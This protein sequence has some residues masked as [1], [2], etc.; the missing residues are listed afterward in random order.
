MWSLR[1]E[2]RCKIRVHTRGL[3]SEASPCDKSLRLVSRCVPTF[4]VLNGRSHSANVIGNVGKIRGNFCAVGKNPSHETR[5]L[6]MNSK[7]LNPTLPGRVHRRLV[8][9]AQ[10]THPYNIVTIN[11][12]RD[13]GVMPPKFY[14]LFLQKQRSRLAEFK[15]G[16]SDHFVLLKL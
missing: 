10:F 3:V 9:Y 13:A 6:K 8:W 2:F 5:T 12:A 11:I 4:N 15:K 14:C 7:E 16:G 1:L